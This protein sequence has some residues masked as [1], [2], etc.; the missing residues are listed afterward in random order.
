M[1]RCLASVAW[2][3][4]VFVV[5]QNVIAIADGVCGPIGF[6][7]VGTAPFPEDG[8]F[9]FEGLTFEGGEDIDAIALI[10]GGRFHIER[11][12]DRGHDIDA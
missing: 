11:S 12:D 8:S 3:G 6:L 9:A 10:T 4:E 2:A 5:E 1:P 7:R